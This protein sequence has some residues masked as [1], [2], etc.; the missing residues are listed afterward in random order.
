MIRA[1]ISNILFYV[2]TI[3]IVI[4]A[5]PTAVMPKRY[6]YKVAHLWSDWMLAMMRLVHD[7][8]FEIR[9]LENMPD[10]KTP[11]VFAPKHQSAWDMFGVLQVVHQPVFAFKN[12][13]I[14]VPVF[15][16]LL[17]KAEL[18]R[19]KRGTKRAALDSLIEGAKLCFARG[20]SL[21]V[22]PE[23]TRRDID[24]PPAYKYGLTYVY[25]N[26][27]VT[28]VPIALNAGLFW[29]RRTFLRWSGTVVMD[30]LPAIPPG[31]TK[32]AFELRLQSCL[33]EATEKLVIESRNK[34]EGKTLKNKSA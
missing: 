26:I 3:T 20:D 11:V 8:K 12:E 2:I 24:A 29:P 28:V 6:L 33:N 19:L 27:D 10:I 4:I 23:G 25:E 5:I 7:L 34:G 14:Y 18:I 32:E 17:F 9:G 15:G 22:F 1:L 21:V 30:I 16:Q 31:L 13:L